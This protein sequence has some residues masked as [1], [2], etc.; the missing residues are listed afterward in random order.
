MS[1]ASLLDEV[2]RVSIR[3]LLHEPFYGHFFSGMIREPSRQIGSIGVAFA[4]NQMVRLLVNPDHWATELTDPD[5]RYGAIK[6]QVLH[7]VLK[8][9]L[10]EREFL[11]R[12]VYW[13]A[14]DLV[15]NQYLAAHHLGPDAIVLTS[16]PELRLRPDQD[17]GYYYEELMRL[18]ARP[19][20]AG[21]EGGERLAKLLGQGHPALA[22]HAHWSDF[23]ELPKT[24]ATLIEHVIEEGIA[25]T[26]QRIK[27]EQYGNLPAGIR[28]Y[29]EA[30]MEPPQLNWRRVMRLF[31]GSSRR[32]Y[33]KET[34]RRP[35][36][37]YGTTPGIKVRR[38]HRVLVAVDTSGS[39][40][41][42]EVAT[43]FGEIH[44]IWRG[45]AEV[46]VVECDTEIH[47]TW[48]Y[49]GRP[50][51]SI[52]GRGGTSFDAPIDYANREYRPDAVIYFTDGY[53]P[54]PSRPCRV[55]LLWVISR[56]GLEPGGQ[57]WRA[58][59]QRKVKLTT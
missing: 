12:Q 7:V 42:E 11:H 21:E 6:H 39:V 18:V 16:F 40:Q 5:Q 48:D 45:G 47:S 52:T 30:L 23:T 35:S 22:E 2:A 58:L 56:E 14:A 32:T 20:G 26:V 43:F 57:P 59:P 29:I 33:L 15:V 17:V 4:S 38:Q 55:P 27:Q 3:I 53:A 44:H 9:V 50:P 28:Q 25:R 37:R 31:A 8:H 1:D 24:E 10:R 13:I 19:E 36:K 41:D 49:R 46:R 51:E 34:L 54:P